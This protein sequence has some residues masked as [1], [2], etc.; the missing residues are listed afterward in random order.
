MTNQENLT[1]ST[2]N[3]DVPSLHLLINEID[4]ALK[5]AE[6]HLSEFHDDEEQ[7]PLLLDSALVIEQLA[8][9]FD[10]IH[11]KGTSELARAISSNLKKLHDSADNSNSDLI[12]DISEGIMI[13]GRYI[14]F[15]L[16]KEMVEPSLILP[17]INKLRSHL[18]EPALSNN[19][20]YKSNNISIINPERHYQSLSQLSIDKNQVIANYRAGLAIALDKQDN[21]LNDDEKEKL[22]ALSASMQSIANQSQTL[23]WQSAAVATKN[24]ADIL[25]LTNAKKRVLIYLE[26][27]LQ[28]YLPIQ[29]RRFAD[30]VSLACSRDDSFLQ[31][32]Q[33]QYGLNQLS[34]SQHNEL[35]RFLFGPDRQIS[36][37]LN[38]LIQ[39]EIVAIKEKVD[40]LARQ[41]NNINQ[42][43]HADI[44]HQIRELAS[45][46]QLLNL[47]DAAN[48]L[49]NA[50]NAVNN[51][52]TP[53]PEDFDTLLA[54]LM[55]AENASIF[56]SKTHT[57]GSVK[58]SLHNRNI[59]LHQ[60]DTAYETLLKE[61]RVN[62]AN[63]SQAINDYMT[64]NNRDLTH[65]QT[66]PE[67]L[68]Q[69]AGAADFLKINHTAKM[70]SRLANYINKQAIQT[71]ATLSNDKLAD[72][73]DVMMAA[74]YHFEAMENNRPISKQSMHIGQYSL[75]RLL[76]AQ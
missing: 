24:L 52:E 43:S 8:S 57:P 47:E 74:D 60:L 16:L 2:T 36:D 54:E 56:L 30:L 14:E 49:K 35:R 4:V 23:F 71:N 69:A 10:L 62:I 76:S 34:D 13:L 12:M 21:Q 67:A 20:V 44:A 19:D 39:D 55:V 53:T 59:S 51:W 11:F 6:I 64:D 75:N 26:Q 42:V 28:N 73:A 5:D 50:A 40:S 68:A 41:D 38:A 37:T 61:S 46:M 25:P 32:A 1:S 22:N 48:A 31:T 70:L 66:A 65:L 72:I 15:V 58:L 27:Q 3:F 7:V 33:N 18:D 63:I 9:I 17:I 45:A 29:D